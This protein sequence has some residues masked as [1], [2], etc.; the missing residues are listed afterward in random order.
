MIRRFRLSLLVA[1]LLASVL[2][3]GQ[4]QGKFI[5]HKFEQPI[6][7]ENYTITRDGERFTLATDF[8]FTDRGS[9]VPLKSSFRGASDYTPEYFMMKGRTSRLSAADLEVQIANGVASVKQDGKTTEEH[10][11]KIFFTMSGY[12]PVAQEMLL[13]RYWKAHGSPAH[14]PTIPTGEVEVTDRGAETF[15]VDGNP[16]KLERYSVRGVAWGIETLWMDQH[17]DLVALVT[18]DAEF[19]HFE[20]IRSGYEKALTRFVASAAKDQMEELAALSKSLPGRKAGAM[21]FTGATLI[22]GRGGNPIA[23]AVVVTQNGKIVAAGPSSSV[24][25]PKGAT[26]VDVKG[27]YIIPGLWDMHAH[28]EQVEWGPIYLAAGVTTVRD[29]GNELEFIAAVRDATNSG[30]GLGPHLLLAGIVDGDS[31]FAIGMNRVNSAADAAKWVHAYHDAGFQQ[32]KIYS[33]MKSENVKAV[34]DEAHKLG[35]TVTGHIPEGM[36]IFDGVN[37]GMDQVNHLHYLSDSFISKTPDGKR[38]PGWRL[39]AIAQLD[40]HSPEMQKEIEFLKQ[41]GTV[42]D[43]TVALNE[44]FMRPA[45]RPMSEY[46][47]GV[48]KVAPELREPLTSGGLPPELAPEGE[49]ALAKMIELLGELRKA[50][51]TLVTGTDQAVPGYSLY[52]ELELY[53]KAGFT[54]MEAL[55]HATIIP[56]KVMKQ[57]AESG[58]IER[59]KRADFAILN[60]DPLANIS[61]VRTVKAVVA[62]GVYYDSAPLWKSVGFQP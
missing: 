13:I 25:I 15:D 54:P 18:R 10:P 49:Q 24:Q 42:I 26:R 3:S 21:A 48:L 8:L 11:Q 30:R 33:S 46:E 56:A 43:D 38:T 52:R 32:M 23:N 20:A 34:A 59:G 9:K 51:V 1:V 28:Y 4:E 5:L 44:F 57:D 45:S 40:L 12:S 60:A 36:T 17:D 2:A 19:D 41:H 6:G 14:L 50:G 55:Q 22:D 31:T 62:N 16:Q 35:M 29:C 39:R 37:D 58:S 47:P 27:K 7:E 61:N 53:V